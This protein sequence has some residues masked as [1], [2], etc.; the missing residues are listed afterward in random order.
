[1]RVPTDLAGRVHRACIVSALSLLG[2]LATLAFAQSPPASAAPATASVAH[3]RLGFFEGT[4]V[5]VGVP[6][7]DNFVETCA[8][9]PEGRRHMVCKS[10][11][12][13]PAGPVEGMSILSYSAEEASYQY[14]GFRSGGRVVA[15]RGTE[16]NGVWQFVGEQ[17]AGA[18][19]TRVR[20]TIKAS[21]DGI[22]SLVRETAIADGP[23]KA[24]PELRTVRVTR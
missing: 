21:A 22:V 6:P 13:S 11:W 14:H 19:L 17:G 5:P 1:M 7:E 10:R 12:T 20:V 8:W 23:W 18:T 3:E 4:W 24:S 16:E 9:L 2:S 15:Q